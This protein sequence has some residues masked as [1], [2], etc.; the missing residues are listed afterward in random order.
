MSLKLKAQF[1]QAERRLVD[2]YS[3]MEAKYARD[4]ERT[5]KRLENCD[6][7]QELGQGR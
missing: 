1:D 4:G 6:A 3:V 7:A 5:R 2:S